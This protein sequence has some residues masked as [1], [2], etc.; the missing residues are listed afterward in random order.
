[1]EI[2]SLVAAMLLAGAIGG[3]TISRELAALFARAPL[4]APYAQ[5][6]SLILVVLAIT[7]ILLFRISLAFGDFQASTTFTPPQPLKD[8]ILTTSRIYK[9]LFFIQFFL[10]FIKKVPLF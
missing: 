4:L 7:K 2:A 9:I 5:A 6:I 3:A 10:F 1:M 8:N